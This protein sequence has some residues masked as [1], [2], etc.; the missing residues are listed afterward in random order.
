MGE[1]LCE[2]DDDGVIPGGGGIEFVRDFV[3]VST[4]S[5]V[6]IIL[7]LFRNGSSITLFRGVCQYKYILT[8]S[9]L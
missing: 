7:I 4:V 5:E 6:V 8:G 1:S 3:V 9:G 2:P